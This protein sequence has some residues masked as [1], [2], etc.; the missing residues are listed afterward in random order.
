MTAPTFDSRCRLGSASGAISETSREGWRLSGAC[1]AS[2]LLH[3]LVFGLVAGLGWAVKEAGVEPAPFQVVP[4]GR[5][6]GKLSDGVGPSGDRPVQTDGPA[7][8]ERLF[9][10]PPS[11]RSWTP[12]KWQETADAAA[13]VAHRPMS[14]APKPSPP[15]AR[16][17]TY[18]E[19]VLQT[20][21]TV[22][23]SAASAAP[24]N[25]GASTTVPRISVPAAG[26]GMGDGGSAPGIAS[27]VTSIAI[28]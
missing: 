15:A 16:R 24:R 13:A 21:A 23:G 11:V 14:A 17:T 3:A 18:R 2:V 6:Q 9:T 1:G 28:G 7:G 4:H 27:R 25:N 5:A 10:A 8:S 22:Q 20:G 12:P 26:I 19:H